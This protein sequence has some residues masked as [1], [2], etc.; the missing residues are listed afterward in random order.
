MHADN[1]NNTLKEKGTSLKTGIKNNKINNN[2]N[3]PIC[4]ILLILNLSAR[5]PANNKPAQ[6]TSKH[7]RIAIL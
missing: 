7:P 2:A 5:N 1:V 6:Y 4:I 3:I